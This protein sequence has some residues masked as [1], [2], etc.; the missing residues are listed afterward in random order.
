MDFVYDD[1]GREEAGYKGYADDCACRAISI[2]TGMPY[3]DVYTMINDYGKRER[4]SKR[5]TTKSSA[6]TGVYKSTFHKIMEDL[7]FEWIPTMK[8]GSGCTT[9][10]R[11]DELP[12][13][14]IICNVSKHY[15]CVI[16]GVIHDTY[17]CSRDGTR[18]VYGYWRVK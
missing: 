10:M 5:R 6:R 12:I 3:K 16:D 15:V 4:N 13:G 9:H 8:I 7:G 1:G 11:K 2:A 18:C 14:T 17:D